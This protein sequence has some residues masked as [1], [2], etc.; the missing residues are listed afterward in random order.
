MSPGNHA[1]FLGKILLRYGQTGVVELLYHSPV[2]F[3]SLLS[4]IQKSG[5]ELPACGL[6]E[7]PQQMDLTLFIKGGNLHTGN[8]G[9]SQLFSFRHSFPQAGDGV[10]VCYRQGGKAD[11]LP[12]TNQFPG[13]ERTVGG[14]GVGMQVGLEPSC[15]A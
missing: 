8:H 13:S 3:F 11:L 6:D 1:G 5:C 14:G 10:M 4:H 2:P 12:Q 7:K 9:D 15:S